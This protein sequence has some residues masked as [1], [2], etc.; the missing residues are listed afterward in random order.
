MGRTVTVESES[1][2]IL[3]SLGTAGSPSNTALLIGYTVSILKVIDIVNPRLGRLLDHVTLFSRFC[4][5]RSAR[6]KE[7]MT[8]GFQNTPR[9]SAN[10]ISCIGFYFLCF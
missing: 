9:R 6:K 10:H 8:G 1:E 5:L 4:Q 2:K 3:K 7:I